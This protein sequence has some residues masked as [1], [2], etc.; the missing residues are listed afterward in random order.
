VKLSCNSAEYG[1][2]CSDDDTTTNNII[3]P[4]VTVVG[5]QNFD[6][7]YSCIYSKASIESSGSDN[8][9]I[10]YKYNTAQTLLDSR[11]TTK[12]HLQDSSDNGT[13]IRAYTFS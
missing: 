8:I 11:V 9:A 13:S 12:L 7:M 3:T 2:V 6:T 4:A 1:T 5:V 10:C